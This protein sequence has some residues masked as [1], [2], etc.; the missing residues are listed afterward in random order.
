MDYT[1]AVNVLKQ[2]DPILA[3]LIE[4]IG[5]C[6]LHQRRQTGNLLDCLSRT[7]VYQQLSTKAASTIHRRFL[8]LYP[9]QS[10]PSAQEL[11]DTPDDV[12][13]SA[14]I[15][16]SKATYLKDLAQKVL[17]GLPA[18]ETL[19][20]MENE[21]IIQVLTQVKGIGTWSAQMV[22][23]FRLDRLDVL[24]VDD[25]GLRSAVRMLYDLEQLPDKKR[26]KQIGEKWQPYGAIAS[27]YLW[28]SLDFKS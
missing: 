10:G 14:G 6:Q 13:R 1:A 17:D 18:L 20:T 27:W 19:A 28:R 4:R 21:A 25:M 22:L 24:A 16:R 2:A 12:L 15:S 23:I 7:I 3:Q 5:P 9:G 8:A 11:L 26:F